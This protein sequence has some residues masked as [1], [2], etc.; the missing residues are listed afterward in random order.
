MGSKSRIARLPCTI[1]LSL[2]VKTM[3]LLPGDAN[4]GTNPSK[5]IDRHCILKQKGSR[6]HFTCY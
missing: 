3:K 4:V 5:S 2:S 1:K 6:K